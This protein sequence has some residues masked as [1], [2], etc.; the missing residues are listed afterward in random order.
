MEYH[1]ENSEA[2][3]ESQ[4]LERWETYSSRLHSQLGMPAAVL[5]HDGTILAASGG[6]AMQP[7]EATT[8][9][10]AFKDKSFAFTNGIYINGFSYLTV[11]A[12]EDRRIYG[13]KGNGGLC[14][15]KTIKTILICT[16]HQPM[17]SVTAINDVEDLADWLI[18]R[19]C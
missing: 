18:A 15:V 4:D 12:D 13:K 7:S 19:G 17:Q 8:L 9:I 5:A 3:P 16:Y 10:K 11:K 1:L 6:F 2:D 14:A